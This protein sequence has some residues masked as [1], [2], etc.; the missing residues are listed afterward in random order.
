MLTERVGVRNGKAGLR[1]ERRRFGEALFVERSSD[2]C[3]SASLLSPNPGEAGSGY[4]CS[5]DS[6]VDR[7]FQVVLGLNNSIS[8]QGVE[9]GGVGGA[10]FELRAFARIGVFESSRSSSHEPE[11]YF[12]VAWSCAFARRKFHSPGD[13]I[14]FPEKARDGGRCGVGD[15]ELSSNGMSAFVPRAFLIQSMTPERVK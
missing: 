1:G 15:V 4:A 3:F 8:S 7:L 2:L 5:S 10:V 11:P 9:G 13:M 6:A 12:N 14:P